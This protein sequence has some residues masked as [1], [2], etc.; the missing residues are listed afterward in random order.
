MTDSSFAIQNL[1]VSS[2]SLTHDSFNSNTF[3]RYGD[4]LHQSFIKKIRSDLIQLFN[5]VFS[6]SPRFTF[7]HHLMDVLRT[8]QF[9]FPSLLV[10]YFN[11]WEFMSVEQITVDVFSFFFRIIPPSVKD[12]VGFI[13]IYIFIGLRILLFV[14]LFFSSTY[15]KRNAKLPNIITQYIALD[16]STL[17]HFLHPIAFLYRSAFHRENSDYLHAATVCFPF[18]SLLL[19]DP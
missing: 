4:L 17:G 1:P 5:Y 12:K 10:S 16:F 11:Y 15:F 3:E 9:L 6:V 7:I 18:R 14:V 2:G 8:L 13:F 19:C